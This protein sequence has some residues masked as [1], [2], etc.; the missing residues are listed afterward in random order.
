MLTL[1]GMWVLD[2]RGERDEGFGVVGRVEGRAG[3]EEG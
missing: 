1:I 2:W 3:E